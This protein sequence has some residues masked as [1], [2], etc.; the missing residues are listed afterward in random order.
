MECS[1]VFMD[2]SDLS[3]HMRKV[4]KLQL[5]GEITLVIWN[6]QRGVLVLP[7][8]REHYASASFIAG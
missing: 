4:H 8:V 6:P 5:E 3:D 1:E 2:W 7:E